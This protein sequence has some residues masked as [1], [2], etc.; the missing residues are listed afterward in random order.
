MMVLVIFTLYAKM[1]EESTNKPGGRFDFL[2]FIAELVRTIIIVT[3]LAYVIRLFVF[4][5]FVVE[6]SSMFPVFHN[7]DYLVVD[8][9]TYDFKAPERGDIIVFRYPRNT[10]VNYVKRIIGLPGE[11]VHIEGGDVTI[12]NSENPNGFKLLE[13]YTNEPDSTFAMTNNV[14]INPTTS[15]TADYTV[16]TGSYFVMGDNR[17]ASS[18]SREWSFLD[19][20]KIIG[21]VMVQAFPLNRFAVVHHARY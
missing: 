12:F 8:K 21:R 4:Q 15:P 1:S 2:I 10:D 17:K 11:R 18:D 5:P 9:V 3:V 16:P 6:G 7:S 19:K 14:D 13:P 20:D